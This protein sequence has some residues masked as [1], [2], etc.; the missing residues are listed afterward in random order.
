MKTI[1]N[2]MIKTILILF[3]FFGILDAPD[4]N[5]KTVECEFNLPATPKDYFIGWVIPGVL[6]ISIT[7]GVLLFLYWSIRINA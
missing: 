7:I 3:W 5:T 4:G 1:D 6:I 2:A